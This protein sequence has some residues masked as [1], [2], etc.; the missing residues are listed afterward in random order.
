MKYHAWNHETSVAIIATCM[1][2]VIND[3]DYANENKIDNKSILH[4]L[5]VYTNDV[6][7]THHLDIHEATREGIGAYNEM[8]SWYEWNDITTQTADDVGA[9]LD[10]SKLKYYKEPFLLIYTMA[11]GNHLSIYSSNTFVY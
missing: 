2:K 4:L 1:V 11:T 6:N 8:V 5:Q 10:K 7:G 9:K 3:R